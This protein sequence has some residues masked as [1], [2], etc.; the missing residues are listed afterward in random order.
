MLLHAAVWLALARIMLLFLP[1]RRLAKRLSAKE[2]PTEPGPDPQFL[3]RIGYAVRTAAGNVPWRSD[4]FPQSIAG[5]MILRH[6]GYT[7]TIHLGVERSGEEDLIG[8]AWL[9]C[10]DAVITGG[11][12]L[13]RYAEIHRLGA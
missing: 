3:K 2:Q 5:S 7:G 12:D 13:H 4:C 10:G 8:H 9:T 1:F 11:E 6:H